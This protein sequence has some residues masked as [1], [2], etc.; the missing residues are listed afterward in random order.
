M[1][2][3]IDMNCDMGESFGH[4]VLGFDEDILKNVSSAS[5]ACGFHAGDYMVMDK[6]VKMAMENNVAIGAHPGYPDLQGFGR[7]SLDMSFKELK[8]IILY[9]IGAIEAFTRARGS[10]LVH[11]KCHGALGN[12]ANNRAI[13]GDYEVVK[14]LGQA[15]LEYDKNMAVMAFAK[16]TMV[17][18]LRDMGVHVLEEVF[19]DRAYNADCSLVSRKKPGS[20]ITSPDEVIERVLKMVKEKVIVTI[21][22]QEIKDINADTICFHGD[23]PTAVELTRNMKEAFEKEGIK[24]KNPLQQ[25]A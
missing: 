10:K 14:A 25:N 15:V 6:T 23:T 19:A 17:D 7:R 2:L 11:V 8:N 24:V 21:D 18:R 4:Y 16:S 9:Q 13:K 12:D 5:I 20:L 1:T 3:S 22:G